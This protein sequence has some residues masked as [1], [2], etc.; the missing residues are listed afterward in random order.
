MD[1]GTREA[2]F[3]TNCQPA[4]QPETSRMSGKGANPQE[5]NTVPQVRESGAATK[6]AEAR[7]EHAS[8]GTTTKA[9]LPIL[10]G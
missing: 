3:L 8:G 9:R 7:P 10:L 2:K 4:S 5:K 1:E 6:P